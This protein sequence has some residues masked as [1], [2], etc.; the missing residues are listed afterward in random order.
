MV[1]VISPPQADRQK[2]I[3][4]FFVTAEVDFS[5]Y[6][7]SLRLRTFFFFG[8][9]STSLEFYYMYFGMRNHKSFNQERYIK[10]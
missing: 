7:A 1:I 10:S 5:L 6:C 4:W 9:T 8:N 3:G 2:R